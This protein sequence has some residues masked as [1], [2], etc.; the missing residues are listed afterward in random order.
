MAARVTMAGCRPVECPVPSLPTRPEHRTTSGRFL[1]SYWLFGQPVQPVRI[2]CVFL[3]LGAQEFGAMARLERH[4]KTLYLLRHA[5][6]SWD[7]PALD[8]HD[9]PLAAR[10]VK[11]ARAV[12]SEI[13][14]RR[15]SV[16]LVLCS[17]AARARQTLESVVPALAHAPDIRIGSEL[18]VAGAGDLLGR[19]RG[20]DEETRAVLIVGHNPAL[21]ELTELL[22]GDGEPHALDQLRRKFPTG[23]LATLTTGRPWGDLG[24]GAACLESLFLPRPPRPPN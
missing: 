9:R 5:K 17:S 1:F 20:L 21:E 23:A 16:D 14:R 13:G 19:L 2:P 7:V 3:L 24:R 4:V 12:A 11:A 8:D 10:G 15:I 18:Y 22:A 6:S